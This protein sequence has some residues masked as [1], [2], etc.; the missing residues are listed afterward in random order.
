LKVDENGDT[1]WSEQF[2]VG[3]IFLM[4]HE[5]EDGEYVLAGGTTVNQDWLAWLIKI[6]DDQEVLWR[7][8][9]SGQYGRLNSM[10]CIPTTDGGYCLTAM[11]EDDGLGMF[12][13]YV[14]RTDDE[15]QRIWSRNYDWGDNG[16][17][18]SIIQTDDAGFLIVG[19]YQSHDQGVGYA[20][21]IDEDG[22]EEWNQSLSEERQSVYFY[23]AAEYGDDYLI[24]G[25]MGM[26]LVSSEGEIADTLDLNE[27]VAAA[28]EISY[29]YGITPLT[30]GGFLLIGS[31]WGGGNIGLFRT[32][33]NLTRLWTLPEILSRAM[34]Q[35][36]TRSRPGQDR[37][38]SLHPF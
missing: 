6:N 24:V 8:T 18:N 34:S 15:G 33:Q 5:A 2:M 16:A 36:G 26:I 17:P 19:K 22:R 13:V 37:Q 30:D 14:L 1:L 38:G 10:R 31:R 35:R 7:R 12:A 23:D 32:D 20:M 29:T 25:T 11:D 27:G 9:Y 3:D 21:K 4:A 28:D